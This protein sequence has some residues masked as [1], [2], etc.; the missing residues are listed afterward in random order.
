V[1]KFISQKRRYLPLE[2][3]ELYRLVGLKFG[4]HFSKK[5]QILSILSFEGHNSPTEALE[6]P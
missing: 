1:K 2:N 4:K 6:V 3:S 5:D